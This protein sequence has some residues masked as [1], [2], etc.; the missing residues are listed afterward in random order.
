M[1]SK[2]AVV[3]LAR[4]DDAARAMLAPVDQGETAAQLCRALVEHGFCVVSPSNPAV[5]AVLARASTVIAEWLAGLMPD[6]RRALD[7]DN[8]TD[9]DQRA[10]G[11]AHH[12]SVCSQL[13]LSLLL[14]MAHVLLRGLPQHVDR[15]AAAAIEAS[16][17]LC[18]E[19]LATL[20]RAPPL[21][22]PSATAFLAL[23][24]DLPL[25]HGSVSSSELVVSCDNGAQQ[26]ES[27]KGTG[28]PLLQLAAAP[29]ACTAHIRAAGFSASVDVAIGPDQL[30][31]VAG[32]ALVAAT[33]GKIK[34]VLEVVSKGCCAVF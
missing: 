19:L 29:G 17:A 34:A 14:R 16:D 31:V 28:R 1:V 4:S 26:Y 20:V 9:A 25:R 27:A 7:L 21:S 12:V 32:E 30:L 11:V 15:L 5:V 3:Q 18:R 24:D 8:A 10:R 23:A 6:E 22:A 2:P 13:T 33:G